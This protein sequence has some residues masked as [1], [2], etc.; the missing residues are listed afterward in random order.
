MYA[1][2]N[3]MTKGDV[4]RKLVQLSVDVK[5]VPV[6]TRVSVKRKAVGTWLIYIAPGGCEQR[7]NLLAPIKEELERRDAGTSNCAV[8]SRVAGVCR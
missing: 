5:R 4:V 2:M 6:R 8:T 7:A 1:S 3:P